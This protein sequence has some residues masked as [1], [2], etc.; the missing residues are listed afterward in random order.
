MKVIVR[1]PEW[2]AS[3]NPVDALATRCPELVVHRSINRNGEM[4][5]LWT[6]TH[7]P[8]G[9]SIFCYFPDPEV[10]IAIANALA[11]VPMDWPTADLYNAQARYLA[12]PVEIRF[13]MLSWDDFRIAWRTKKGL[14]A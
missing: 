10:A 11:G 6:I 7:V 12:L 13:W 4:E 3:P 14:A 5:D 8:S 9:C 1:Y 2:L